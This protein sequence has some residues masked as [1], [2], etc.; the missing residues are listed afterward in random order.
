M[1]VVGIGYALEDANLGVLDRIDVLAVDVHPTG[2]DSDSGPALL[3]IRIPPNIDLVAHQL[4]VGA[5]LALE[6]DLFAA[7]GAT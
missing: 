5:N 2:A 6:L 7:Q 1:G 4:V 3:Q